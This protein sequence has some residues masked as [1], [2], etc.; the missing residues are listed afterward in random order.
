[1]FVLEHPTG[2]RRKWGLQDADYELTVSG[3][4]LS[5]GAGFSVDVFGYL[6]IG[7]A[8]EFKMTEVDAS[9][10]CLRLAGKHGWCYTQIISWELWSV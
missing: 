1:L 8:P 10:I 9:F 7:P 4:D 3:D 5:F 2:E 6:D